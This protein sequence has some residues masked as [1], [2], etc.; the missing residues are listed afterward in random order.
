MIRAI[1]IILC[2]IF[3]FFFSGM[4]TGV[5]L[6][7]RARV[8]YLKERGSIGARILLDLFLNYPGRLSSTVLVGN[9]IVNG[10]ATVLVAQWFLRSDGPLHAVGAVFLFAFIL[11]FFGELVPK[12][13]FR[14]FPNRLT[15]LL[16]PLLLVC[17][18]ILWP[19][20]Q[21]FVFLSQVVVKFIGGKITSRQMFVTRDE[22]KL[23]AREGKQTV[24]V[25]GEQQNLIASILDSQSATAKD[26][27][28]PKDQVVTVKESQ[29]QEERLALSV[30][31][32]YSRL[33]IESGK[34]HH[35]EGLWVAY[36]S[37]FTVNIKERIPPLIST[38]TNLE[39]ILNILRRSKSPFAFVKDH[40]GKDLGIITVEDVLRRYIGKIDL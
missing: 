23:M 35:W 28:K 37:L 30:E 6:L 4:E 11:W 16:A 39:E 32:N 8:R 33:P 14:R 36:D 7:N 13:L 25:S 9:T 17:F 10:V 1:A 34:T 22:L 26:I 3:S 27:M 31:K 5:L 38:N 2:L 40:D 19:I 21:I 20:I 18:S 12:A 29:T 24:V 15:T